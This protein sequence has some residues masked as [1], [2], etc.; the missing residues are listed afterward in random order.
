MIERITKIKM[1]GVFSG[2]TWN[3]DL[4]DF[5]QFN[6]LYGW[7][8]SG[9]T[10]LS[11]FFRCIEK[12]QPIAKGEVELLISGNKVDGS[13]F[14]S[15]N[16]LPSTKVFNRDFIEDVV[17]KGK[18]PEGEE[19]DI[20]PIFYIGEESA[21]A[22]REIEKLEEE[23]DTA[24]KELRA[25]TGK[26]TT[27]RANLDRHR[28]NKAAT[29]KEALRS[30]DATNKY[31]N[32]DKADYRTKVEELLKSPDISK[33]ILTDEQHLVEK[34]R[35]STSQLESV[36][37]LGFS[38]CDITILR[39]E[40]VSICETKVVSQVIERLKEDQ[41]LSDWVE[42]GL[43][44][45][46]VQ[47]SSSCLFC[48][49]A[50]PEGKLHHLELHFSASFQELTHL[51][52]SKT[53]ELEE[54]K[55]SAENVKQGLPKP[56][57]LYPHVKSQYDEALKSLS[58][59][60]K[61]YISVLDNLLAILESKRAKAFE[62]VEVDEIALAV[63][64]TCV[65]A[66][67]KLLRNH[68]T[69]CTNYAHGI[70]SSRNKIENSLVA[71]STKEYEKLS[72]AVSKLEGEQKLL[73]DGIKANNDAIKKL[74]EKIIQHQK[75]AEELNTD[76]QNYLG[77]DDLQL[78]VEENGY[79]ITRNGVQATNLSESEKTAI[80]FLYFLKSLEDESFDK[81][82]GVVV[83]D[84]P[85]SSLDANSLFNAFSFMKHRTNTV[86]QLFIMTHS[87]SFFRQ[88]RNWFNHMNKEGKKGKKMK[89][90]SFY[91]ICCSKRNGKR[92]ARIEQLDPLLHEF[93]SE[94]HYLFKL[95]YDAVN[96]ES[97][98]G[99][100]EEYYHLPNEARR[101]LEAFLAFR[102]PGTQ[103]KL[104]QK[105][106]D[107]NFDEIKETRILRLLHVQSHND[108]IVEPDH[109]LTALSEAKDVLGDVLELMRNQDPAHYAGMES[110]V[111]KGEED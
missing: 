85:V 92:E 78:S 17:F 90:T 60:T 77:R 20:N 46:N 57:E 100:L 44:L 79:K 86:G 80:A 59:Q 97:A 94:Y 27:A 21:E 106:Q 34:N 102:M 22:K 49:Q 3:K 81:S 93:E 88:V 76:L 104:Y 51:V 5:R 61:T 2:F 39:N 71:S 1:P 13:N 55:Q 18:N 47:K 95:I 82:K 107:S 48:E 62:V 37:E 96:S 9:K 52:D 26:A 54:A 101:L 103:G 72:S 24:Q 69:E 16:T 63:D 53:T 105:L 25:K 66:I 56:R 30:S 29:V 50:L 19:R 109:D 70:I 6:V 35:V 38:F 83:I 10:T 14:D 75:P 41:E 111:T 110:L 84:D 7:N 74:E 108:E 98:V 4:Q 8:A 67:N 68:N 58:K 99:K 11:R 64:T 65:E 87:F 31:N 28:I 15:D 42:S 43:A 40:V 91:L 23:R 36:T 73:S 12:K 32:F 45:H 89:P 33:H